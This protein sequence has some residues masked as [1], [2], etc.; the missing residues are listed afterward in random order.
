[1]KKQRQHGFT[2]IEILIVVVILSIL[3]IA[4]VPQFLDQPGKARVARAQSDISNLKKALSMYK[5]DNFNYPST[6]QGLQALVSKPGG[7]PE[8]K[9]WKPGGYVEK[10]V[11]DPWGN[12][13]QYLNP[14]NHGEVDIYSFGADGQPGGEG[15][16]QDVGNW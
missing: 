14:G 1:M 12:D 10:L 13:Y 4:V 3:A 16:N 5:L 15:E 6:S 2:L 8:A 11:Q 7:Q 9:N